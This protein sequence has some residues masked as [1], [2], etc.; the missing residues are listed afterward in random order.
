M[1]YARISSKEFRELLST[2]FRSKKVHRLRYKNFSG[3]TYREIFTVSV[4]AES[5]IFL[6]CISEQG[7]WNFPLHK[8]F[9]RNLMSEVLDRKYSARQAN[10]NFCGTIQDLCNRK[11][12]D[13]SELAI[14]EGVDILSLK[15]ER[16]R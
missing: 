9:D 14:M 2:L 1:Q 3:S 7:S 11:L 6:H 12:R 10:K 15:T 16:R 4:H 5:V 8:V 13:L